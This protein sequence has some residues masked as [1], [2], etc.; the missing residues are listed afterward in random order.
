MT[1]KIPFGPSRHDV[2]GARHLVVS[3]AD[4]LQK[5]ECDTQFPSIAAVVLRAH[6]T[7]NMTHCSSIASRVL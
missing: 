4:A 3:A 2:L 6:Y 7:C 5:D 1:Q